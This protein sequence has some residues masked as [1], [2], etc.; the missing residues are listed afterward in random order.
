MIVLLLDTNPPQIL[1]IIGTQFFVSLLPELSKEM[2]TEYIKPI[3]SCGHIVI[4]IL[5]TTTTMAI[6]WRE[7]SVGYTDPQKRAV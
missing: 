2:L 4:S 6:K 1:K 7:P 3:C 5:H